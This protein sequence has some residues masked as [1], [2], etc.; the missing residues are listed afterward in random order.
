MTDPAIPLYKTIERAWL[1][2]KYHDE[3]LTQQK[4]ADLADVA[5]HIVRHAI[6]AYELKL[7]RGQTA[8][9]H[10]KYGYIDPEY[11]RRQYHEY[12]LT[13]K[14]IA[15]DLDVPPLGRGHRHAPRGHSPP[16]SLG[17]RQTHP[18]QTLARSQLAHKHAPRARTD[19]P[20]DRRPLRL[21]PADHRQIH[22]QT[23]HRRP[24]RWAAPAPT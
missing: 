16:P 15:A 20:A 6:W 19:L 10:S 4:I 3:G 8:R 18:L 17:L 22:A 7:P 12:G 1:K 2:R 14:E 23:R 21:P 13:I 24:P 9:R 5:K 11:I